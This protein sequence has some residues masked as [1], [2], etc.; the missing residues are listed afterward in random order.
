MLLL[1][2]MGI[3]RQQVAAQRNVP[4]RL[5]ADSDLPLPRGLVFGPDG[6]LYVANF[7]GGD[8]LRFNS[9]R[10]AF[11]ERFIA[12]ARVRPRVAARSVGRH[13]SYSTKRLQAPEPSM[14]GIAA[15]GFGAVLLGMLKRSRACPVASLHGSDSG[16][17]R[18]LSFSG[19]FPDL[20]PDSMFRQARAS[21]ERLASVPGIS[22]RCAWNE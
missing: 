7:G 1:G 8:V 2:R 10:G 14:F 20:F 13:S 4:W 16:I 22:C 11:I 5:C 19:F 17:G 12:V 15:I 21:V 3:S 9:T 18:L 6:N